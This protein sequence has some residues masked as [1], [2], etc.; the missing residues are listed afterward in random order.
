[1]SKQKKRTYQSEMLGLQ[2]LSMV[3]VHAENDRRNSALKPVQ[4][5]KAGLQK[6]GVKQEDLIKIIEYLKKD[7]QN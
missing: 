4:K 3:L 2:P 1:M 7:A 5:P 6:T